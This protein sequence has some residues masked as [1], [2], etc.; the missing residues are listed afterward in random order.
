MDI[1]FKDIITAIALCLL[2]MVGWQWYMQKYG[3]QP[4]Q[5]TEQ[6]QRAASRQAEPPFATGGKS[7][8]GE[9]S[10]TQAEPDSDDWRLVPV[11]VRA[12][13]VI[14]GE[15]IYREGGYKAQITINGASAALEEVLLSEHKFHVTDKQTGYPLIRAC[16]DEHQHKKFGL[17]LGSLKLKNRSEVF[18]LSSGCWRVSSR[19]PA[20]SPEQNVEF[21]ASISDKANRPVLDIVKSYRYVPEDYELSFA[22][23]LVNRGGQEIEIESLELLGMMGLAREDPRSDRRQ[24]AAGY[25]MAGSKEITIERVQLATFE[26]PQN[27]AK[28][29]LEKPKGASLRWLAVTNKFFAAIVRPISPGNQ[30]V[31]FIVN[32]QVKGLVLFYEDKTAQSGLRN[33]LGDIVSLTSER[34]LVR[35]AQENFAFE[36]FLGPVD[37]EIF[38]QPEYAGLYYH[39]LLSTT[40]CT[41]CA[42]DWLTALVLKLMKGTYVIVGNYGVAIIILVLL[43]RL[44]LHPISKK[45][46]INMMKMGKIGPQIEELKKKYGDDKKEFQRRQMGLMKDQGMAGNMLL[47]CLPMFLQ[48][49]I[50]IALYTAVDANVAIRHHGLFPASW[51]WL[52]DLSAPDRLVPFSW[53]GITEPMHV[54]MIGGVDGFNL[55]PILLF[56]AMFLQMKYS[57]QSK[58]T[59]ANPQ[60]AQQQKI[61]MYMMPVMMLLFFYTAPSGLNLYIM[62]STFGGLI[63]QHFIRKHLKREEAKAAEVKVSI[64]SKIIER[65]GP[66]KRKPKPPRKYF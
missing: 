43:V 26:K 58:M 24:V 46:Q 50:W 6:P 27:A 51:H 57:P 9:T 14:F 52:T 33:T 47:G 36:I 38:A 25:E 61:M 19:S 37:R 64:T 13:D 42:F 17:G 45:S 54:P 15:R 60:A 21:T 53:F 4:E 16:Y 5:P 12:E 1:D 44:V 63:E 22:V 29:L 23:R 41:F 11:Q 65:F 34:P 18:D 10:L 28:A 35:G 31:E 62:A 30:P 7:P 39:K 20:D 2:I 49:P 66:K 56:V 48:M 55:L 32:D 3:S 59:T 40:S 8:S